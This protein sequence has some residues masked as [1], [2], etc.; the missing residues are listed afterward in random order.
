MCLLFLK[1][2]VNR[3]HLTREQNRINLTGRL[4]P[5]SAQTFAP[6]AQ[7]AKERGVRVARNPPE[8]VEFLQSA[9]ADFVYVGG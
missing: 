6:K 5:R 3:E 4:K 1:H 9:K 2:S 7:A 8:P